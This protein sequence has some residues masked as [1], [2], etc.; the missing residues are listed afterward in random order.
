MLRGVSAR[1]RRRPQRSPAVPGAEDAR[2]VAGLGG[3][4]IGFRTFPSFYGCENSRR[5]EE[6]WLTT[7]GEQE[8]KQPL[9]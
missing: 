9:W 5:W 7:F 6:E 2:R 3:V 1:L 8:V 4:L